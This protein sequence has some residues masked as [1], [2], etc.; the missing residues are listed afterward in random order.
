MV[1]VPT[2]LSRKFHLHDGIPAVIHDCR[3]ANTG[4]T[5]W[6]GRV[7]LGPIDLE[8]LDVK[9]GPLAGLPVTVS[10]RGPQ[11]SHAVVIPTLD[12]ECS[13]QK[14]GVHDRGPRQE[15]PLL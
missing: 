10:G 15:V 2:I 8:M 5:G 14:T 3:P 7:L 9:T 11:Q 6:L 1:A 12:Q 4:L 13:V